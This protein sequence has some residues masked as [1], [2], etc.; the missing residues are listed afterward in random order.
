MWKWISYDFLAV[1]KE[2]NALYNATIRSTY[3]N[4]DA[5]LDDASSILVGYPI[6]RQLRTRKGYFRCIY[7]LLIT[8]YI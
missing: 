4:F 2:N 8:M 7:S 6:L 3:S 1:L 5:Y